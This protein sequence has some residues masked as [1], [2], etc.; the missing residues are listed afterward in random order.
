MSLQ[1]SLAAVIVTYNRLD[2]L[3][4]VVAALQQQTR[5]PERIF[6]VD[7]AST[8]GTG[9]W[10]AALQEEDPRF[11]HVR[12]PENIGGAGGFHEGARVAYEDG[13]AYVWFS[14][15]DAYP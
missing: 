12:L 15:D 3:K 2:K 13:F 5:M 10:L 6:M 9:P 11:Q 8:D 7:N 14:D 1:T 4:Q